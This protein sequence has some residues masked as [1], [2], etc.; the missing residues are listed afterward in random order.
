MPAALQDADRFLQGAYD[1]IDLR[2]PSIGDENQLHRAAIR[3]KRL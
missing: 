3:A 1:A 2:R